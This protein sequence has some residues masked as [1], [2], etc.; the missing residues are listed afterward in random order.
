MCY[1][2]YFHNKK[3]GHSGTVGFTVA[4]Q[5]KVLDS[6]PD[7]G[8]FHVPVHMWVLYGYSG[9]L[10]RSKIMTIRLICHSKTGGECGHAWMFICVSLECPLM[11]W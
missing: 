11:E 6:N 1:S 5:Q 7:R 2:L 9:L 4:V 10:P 8:C 3:L